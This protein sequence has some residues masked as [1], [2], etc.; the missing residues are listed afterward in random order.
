MSREQKKTL[1]HQQVTAVSVV[2]S[3][4]PSTTAAG[5]T[6]KASAKVEQGSI[7]VQGQKIIFDLSESGTSARFLD[8]GSQIITRMTDSNGETFPLVEF[9]DAQAQSGKLWAY[10]NGTFPSDG[11][12]C[13]FEFTSAVINVNQV[14]LKVLN[15]SATADGQSADVVIAT[16]TGAQGTPL[17]GRRVEFE[18]DAPAQATPLVDP[19]VSDANGRVPCKIT[20]TLARKALTVNATCENVRAMPIDVQF[21]AGPVSSVTL[22]VLQDNEIAD[23][24]SADLVVASVAD[25]HGNMIAGKSVALSISP[26]AQIENGYT[27]PVTTAAGQMMWKI[28]SSNV[29]SFNVTATADGV[30]SAPVTIHFRPVLTVDF[31]ADGQ[32]IYVPSVNIGIPKPYY[33]NARGQGIPDARI[34]LILNDRSLGT[35]STD[36]NGAW[37]YEHLPYKLGETNK[38]IAK[39]VAPTNSRAT[40]RSSFYISRL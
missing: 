25:R 23:G 28:R 5:A 27:P 30:S 31:P 35:I 36:L 1:A 10:V 32:N 20:S 9:S 15:D 18:V 16:V 37:S 38:L 2:P 19:P 11:G 14:T 22:N 40:A 17:A 34:E 12:A 3:V 7:P 29:G 6:I 39:Y 26:A 13:P 4:T 21:V 24:D 33:I 8:N